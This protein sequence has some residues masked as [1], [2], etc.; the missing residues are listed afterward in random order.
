MS[1]DEPRAQFLNCTL[2]TSPEHGRHTQ[3]LTGLSTRITQEQGCRFERPRPVGQRIVT[4]ARRDMTGHG[5]RLDAL[6]SCHQRVTAPYS[7]S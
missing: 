1:H 6:P 5:R 4:G 2:K 7:S 3:G